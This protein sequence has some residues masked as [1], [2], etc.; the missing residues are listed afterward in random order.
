[1]RP[2]VTPLI[3]TSLAPWLALWL[4]A[5]GAVH[6]APADPW[7]RFATPVF[8][9]L[10]TR[11]GLPHDAVTDLAQDA[12][13]LVWIGTMGGLVRYDGYRLQVMSKGDAPDTLPDNY[14]RALLPLPGGGVL[15]ATN[16]GGLARYDPAT[17]RFRRYLVGEG[18]TAHAK[19]FALA[20]DGNGGVWIATEVGLDRLDL[21]A[22]VIERV[23]VGLDGHAPRSHRLFGVMQDSRGNLWIGGK[24]GMAVRRAG[25]DRFER[26]EAGDALAAP[27]LKSE[28]WAFR[29]DGAGRVWFGTDFSG[30]AYVDPSDGRVRGVPGLTGADG[31]ANRRTVRDIAEAE[32]GRLWFATD[33]AGVIVADTGSGTVDRL[34]ADLAVP[35]TLNGEGVRALMMDDTGNLWVGTNRGAERH[36]AWARTVRS[37]FA[38][39][40]NPRALSQSTVFSA[41]TDRRGRIWAGL[42]P[43]R[44][45]V[46][47]PAA[48]RVH[49]L[50]L[51]E[52]Q[53]GRDVQALLEEPGGGI[54]VGSL[55]VARVD[56]DTLAISPSVVP[57]VESKVVLFVG[58]DGGDLMVG[59]Y[60]GLYRYT[61]ATGACVNHRADPADADSL[62]DNHV[63]VAL[64]LPDGRL[65]VGTGGG[66]SIQDPG[67]DGFRNLRPDP[68]DPTALPQGYV[69][70]IVPDGMGRV[71]ISTSGGGL[72]VAGAEEFAGRPRFRVLGRR[73]GL[74]HDNVDG[75][76]PDGLGRIWAA[77]PTSLAVVDAGTLKVR[78]LGERDGLAVD[79]YYVRSMGRGPRRE[80]LFGGPAGLSVVDPGAIGRAPPPARLAVTGLSVNQAALPPGRIPAD[81]GT[82]ELG[83]EQ[84]GLQVD[85]ALLDYRTSAD[86]RYS[87]RLEGFDADW[88]EAPR[89]MPSATYT[90]L[91]AGRYT[92]RARVA[93]TLSGETLGEL[94]LGL[95]IAPFWYESWWFRALLAAAALGGVA[96]IV[97]ARTAILRRRQRQLEAVVEERTRSLLEAK[98]AAEAA[99]RAK[100]AF[101]ASMS[102]EI[103]TPL[104]GVIGFNELLL[105]SPL[106]RQ[107]RE[108]ARVVQD[109]GRSLLTVVNDVLDFSRVEAGMMELAA[110]PFD[111]AELARGSAR[112]VAVAAAEKGLALSVEL[113]DDLPPWLSGDRNRLRQVLLNLLNNAVKFT[114]R[115]GIALAASRAAGGLRVEVRDTG[116]GIPAD[117]LD[118]LF[119]RF[120]QVDASTARRHGGAGLGLA[121]SKA[122]VERM[123]G[124]IGVESMFGRG[125][126]FWLEVPLPEAAAPEREAAPA[127]AGPARPLR[128]LLAEDL[129]ANRL[130]A[131]AILGKA[132]H[133]V[134]TAEDGMAAVE[135]ARAGGYDLIL[136]DVQMPVMDGLEATRAIRA[137][138]GPAGRV[139][140]LALTANAL[141][142]EAARCRAAGMDDHV[143][144]PIERAVLLAAL[145]RW[146]APPPDAV[147]AAPAGPSTAVLDRTVWDALSQTVGPAVQAQL[148]GHMRDITRKGLEAILAAPDDRAVVRRQAH[149]LGSMAGSLGFAALAAASRAAERAG[150]LDAQPLEPAVEALRT[151]AEEALREADGL[152]A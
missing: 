2:G 8:R 94:S 24:P 86:L 3:R 99:A 139:P 20:A 130:L 76:I 148:L 109:A 65:L 92:L 69:T 54:L 89:A 11:D 61:P 1:M 79:S 56:P 150:A 51:P 141:P 107:Q 83:A 75:L 108:W 53:A 50:R 90:N 66:V 126:T 4:A 15:V 44:V 67:A 138:P 87:Y 80:V 38:S 46:F 112:I 100:S 135:K 36:D 64:R 7:E 142:E 35:A 48:D 144:K 143:P 85:F 124:R 72:A 19:L 33:G 88:I 82:L 22:D 131:A 21:A 55:G 147:P 9:D 149:A 136:M 23:P 146:G 97:Q 16:A 133:V 113:A 116:I 74:P 110:E 118:R 18:G 63:R 106:D 60:D 41:M 32:P 98:E 102:H 25:S 73:D 84:R 29:E 70:E 5:A 52:P 103:R 129:A 28:V 91:P 13:G 47:D 6:A 58:R 59:T 43:G 40:T 134:D 77:T 121:I 93:S 96:A 45:D 137:M 104:N 42:G 14:V 140:I 78:R 127:A 117:R 95:A 81:G 101:L 122:I 119:Q 132:G 114:E 123:G 152:A 30:A 39:P 37:I 10:T 27:L 145:A 12:A 125:S 111:P 128:I 68:A 115:G 62:A 31:Q 57:C 151:A 49:R 26:L 105:E 34:V 17:G 71:W 120:S